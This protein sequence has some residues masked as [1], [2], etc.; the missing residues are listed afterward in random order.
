MSSGPTADGSRP[1]RQALGAAG[2]DAVARHYEALGFEVVGRNWRDGRRG[3][4]DLIVRR[5]G[6]VV[7]VEV[8]T[9]TGSAFGDPLEAITRA[10]ALRLRR[11][12]A[13]W[14]AGHTAPGAPVTELRVDVAA[15][16]WAAA[17]L[18]EIEIVEAAC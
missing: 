12:I 7:A 8:K 10:K 13:A 9:R 14:A 6:L 3:E 5:G 4:L 11:L 16:R 17:T 1:R 15:V 2:E 18:P